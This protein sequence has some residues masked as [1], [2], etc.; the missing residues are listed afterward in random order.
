[1]RDRLLSQLRR[2]HAEQSGAIML[3]LLAAFLILFMCALVLF[4]SGIATQDKMDVQFAADTATFSHSVVKARGMNLIA[5][6]NTIK[7][8]MFS[9]L[10]TYVNAWIAIIVTLAWYWARC[11]WRRPDRCIKAAVETAL[12]LPMMISE[13][14]ELLTTNIPDT[15]AF[16]FP[17]DQGNSPTKR[18]MMVLEVYQQYIFA[19]T[20]W[21]AYVEGTMRGIQNGAQ[22]TASWPP[23]TNNY[24]QVRGAGGVAGLLS[25]ADGVFGT[26]FANAP[27]SRNVDVLPAA[28]RDRADDNWATPDR[29]FEFEGYGPEFSG[30]WPGW[31]AI[32]AG[33]QYCLNYALSLESIATGLQTILMS[34]DHPKGWKWVF[35][36]THAL[37]SLGCG[38]AAYSYNNSGYL[39]WRIPERL[40]N[41]QHEWWQATGSLAISY[42]PHVGRNDDSGDRQKFQF[43][44]KEASFDRQAYGNEGYFGMARS[45]L[46][47]KQ[48]FTW[49][50][51][52]ENWVNGL[53]L[54][55]GLLSQRLGIQDSPDL[56]SPRWKSKNRPVLLPGE[57]FGSAIS[58]PSVGFDQVAQDLLPWVALSA[59]TGMFPGGGSP[60]SAPLDIAY[61]YR[62]TEGFNMTNSQGLAK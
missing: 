13:A 49:L 55:G 7:R 39:D 26:A 29:P 38:F 3:L 10:A 8:M 14:I 18:E 5:Y 31:D 27:P 19:I 47:Y 51:S 58:S 4:D 6:T 36:I 23:P 40:E 61:L 11:S 15:S 32:D 16:F 17:G 22:I 1:M 12:S 54:S 41:N 9:F 25:S 59:A 24:A 48:P 28:R 43:I 62:A 42:D 33:L 50:N 56:W 60:V 30:F 53:P 45:E 44:S 21:W 46:V 34:E 57:N 20:P 37:P 35:G 2:I 52:V